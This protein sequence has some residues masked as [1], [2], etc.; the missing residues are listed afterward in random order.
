MSIEQDIEDHIDSLRSSTLSEEYY[1]E[2]WAE[3]FEE[4]VNFI[5]TKLEM[6]MSKGS[7]P[8]PI[9]DRKKFDENWDRIFGDKKNEEKK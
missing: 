5:L 7:T 2:E 8:R 9:T 6:I 1:S 3:G 4:G